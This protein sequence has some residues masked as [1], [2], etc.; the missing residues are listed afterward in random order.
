MALVHDD[1]LR[2]ETLD[3]LDENVRR[4]PGA[5]LGAG[6][7]RVEVDHLDHETRTPDGIR[8]AA[9]VHRRRGARGHRLA[10][11]RVR[12][13]PRDDAAPGGVCCP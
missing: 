11:R 3:R 12:V 4:G 13:P 10:H 6:G 1:H 2:G 9:G 5:D 7:E 8:T